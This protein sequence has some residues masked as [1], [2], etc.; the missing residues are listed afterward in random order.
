MFTALLLAAAIAPVI[1]AIAAER[2]AQARLPPPRED[3]ERLER[4]GRL[5][6]APR[7]AL[8]DVDLGRAPEAERELAFKAMG[9]AMQNVDRTVEA[10]VLAMV[11]PEGWFSR[12]KYGEEASRAAFMIIQHSSVENWRRFLPVIER[13]VAQGEASGADYALMYDRLATTEGRPQRYGSQ[14]RC[15]DGKLAP[16]PLEDASRVEAWRRE[17]GMPFTY[18]EQLANL[19]KVKV[20]CGPAARAAKPAP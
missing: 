7:M 13:F 2:A 8:K 14:L 5:D 1:D 6:Q 3:R 15:V 9:A 17:A 11:P 20:P 18:A 4:L 16:F 12:S 19:S 10:Q